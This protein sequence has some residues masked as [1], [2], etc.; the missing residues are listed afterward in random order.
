[1]AHEPQAHIIVVGNEKGGSGK[2]TTSMHLITALLRMGF[3]VASIDLDF[4]QKSLTRY[5]EN[6]AKSAERK[7]ITLPM[8]EHQVIP[9]STLPVVSEAEAEEKEMF[10]AYLSSIIGTYDFI[11]IDSPGSDT[12]LSRLAHSYADTIITPVNDSFLDLDVLATV[13]SAKMQV[14]RPSIY[15]EAVWKHKIE[16][17]SRSGTQVDWVVMRNRLSNLDARNKRNMEKV[18][19]DLAKRVGFRMAPGFSERVIFRELFLEGLTVL[20]VLEQKVGVSLNLSHVAARQEV[21]DLLGA[22]D[23]PAIQ[24]R[25]EPASTASFG[26]DSDDDDDAEPA[27]Y[28]SSQ[29]GIAEALAPT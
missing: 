10:E 23:I 14:V 11:I 3:S 26:N 13:D 28:R 19:R 18:L 29:A 22:L 5:L 15:S 4:R 12:Y 2:T 8:P 1:M 24:Q 17:A 16:K 6:R 7:G 20:D 21:R 9:R 25:L 27:A